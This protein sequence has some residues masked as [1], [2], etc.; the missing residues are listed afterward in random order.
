L[1]QSEKRE[2]DIRKNSVE[3]WKRAK[4]QLEDDITMVYFYGV[5]KDHL[6]EDHPAI[7]DEIDRLETEFKEKYGKKSTFRVDTTDESV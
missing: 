7:K 4:E 3:E 2:L 6:P 5:V 1:T